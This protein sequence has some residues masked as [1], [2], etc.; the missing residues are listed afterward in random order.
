[1]ENASR[2][3]AAFGGPGGSSGSGGSSGIGSGSSGGS[4]GL[5]GIVNNALPFSYNAE[6][7]NLLSR[8]IQSSIG[9]IFVIAI[10]SFLFLI[11]WGA[12][13]WILSGGDKGAV[14]AAQSRITNAIIGLIVLF[15]V[16]AV[17]A[18]IGYFLNI[19]GLQLPFSL[20][21]SRIKIN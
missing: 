19:P 21:L 7:A 13:Q 16:F 14:Q 6:G 5:E 4:F 17:V 3:L 15:G 12:V 1:M 2:L 9:L 8:F 11:A 18:L 10:I 20:D